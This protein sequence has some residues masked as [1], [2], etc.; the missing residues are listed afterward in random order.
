[1]NEIVQFLNSADLTDKV[2]RLLGVVDTADLCLVGSVVGV[3]IFLGA[4]MVSGKPALKGWGLRLAAATFLLHAGYGCY[5]AGGLNT[6]QLSAI[7]V[8][9]GVAAAAVMAVTWIVLPVLAFVVGRARL[10]TAGFLAYGCYGLLTAP[11]Y[12]QDIL[13][14][15]ALRSFLAAGLALVVAWI[16]QPV[17]DFL[18]PARQSA[19]PI[20]TEPDAV[21]PPLRE[22]SQ[23]RWLSRRKPRD[24]Q[25]IAE[26][27]EEISTVQVEMRRRRDRVRLKVELNYILAAPEIGTRL[28]RSQ[29]EDFVHRYLGDHL[30]PEEVEENGR[31]LQQLLVQRQTASQEPPAVT[32][33]EDVTRW[34]V[35]EQQRIEELGL[36]PRDKESRLTQ[37][38]Q[39]YLERIRRLS[40]VAPPLVL[41]FSPFAALG[42]R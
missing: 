12:S 19:P 4:R 7:V 16:L 11:E 41:P 26:E 14:A 20:P 36:D 35:E 15:I 30:P 8:R 38:H 1:M 40:T 5:L 27:A 31:Q 39:D 25:P 33:L 42:Q 2:R 9:A 34:F 37:L 23:R 24:P 17:W 3:L 32:R 29:F 21:P 13:H 6:P 22:R 28:P 10:A 18:F